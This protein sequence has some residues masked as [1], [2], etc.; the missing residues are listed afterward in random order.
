MSLRALALFRYV[1]LVSGSVITLGIQAGELFVRL[2][3]ALPD[4]RVAL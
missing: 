4:S 1:R 3:D 2:R